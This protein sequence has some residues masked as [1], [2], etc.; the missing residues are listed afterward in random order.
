[1][2]YII[3]AST[4]EEF[5]RLD[6]IAKSLPESVQ[7]SIEIIEG[8]VVGNKILLKKTI[9]TKRISIPK[10]CNNM[11]LDEKKEYIY[12]YCTEAIFILP[13]SADNGLNI[14]FI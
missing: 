10:S 8:G 6:N 5:D 14:D 1:M 7:E 2:E 11:F 4:R 13:L 9:A 3:S 12:F